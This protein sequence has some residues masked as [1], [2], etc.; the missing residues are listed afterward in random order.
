MTATGPNTLTFSAT[1]N[2]G[3]WVYGGSGNYP[4]GTAGGNHGELT[5][6]GANTNGATFTG[7]VNGTSLTVSG[8]TGTLSVGQYVTAATGSGLSFPAQTYLVGGSGTSWTL[9]QAPGNMNG[10]MVSPYYAIGGG[11]QPTTI[12]YSYNTMLMTPSTAGNSNTAFF[13]VSTGSVGQTQGIPLVQWQGSIDHNVMVNNLTPGFT[14]RSTSALVEF[15]YNSLG[16][17]AIAKNYVD[18]TG[19]FYCWPQLQM[20][21]GVAPVFSG[22]VNLLKPSDGYINQQDIYAAV[23]YSPG[24]ASDTQALTGIAYNSATGVVT[25]TLANNTMPAA[26]GVGT[27]IVLGNTSVS[28][29]TNYLA[30]LHTVTGIS[31]NNLTFTVGTGYPGTPSGSGPTVTPYV[32]SGVAES[33]FGHN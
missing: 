14:H 4:T 30:G 9:N 7:S 28:S 13:Y 31:G 29:G 15:A 19:A 24:T 6:A 18:P 16:N 2:K 10:A 12:Q 26:I 27:S 21:P 20:G 3:D 5:E 22:N 11:G 33:C 8:L 1:A 32:T 23:G 17:L 25:V